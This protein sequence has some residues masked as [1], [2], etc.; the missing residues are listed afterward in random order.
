MPYTEFQMQL[1]KAYKALNP[2]WQPPP[3][4]A[5]THKKDVETG[6]PRLGWIQFVSYNFEGY[7]YPQY[8]FVCLLGDGAPEITAGY[9]GWEAIARARNVAFVQWNG[10][11][12]LTIK[13]PI[14]FDNWS[15]GTS[16][17]PDIRQ[18]EKM[19]GAEIN[20]KQPP[21]ILIDS[22]GV[23]PHD[24]HDASQNDWVIAEIEWGDSDRNEHGNRVRQ[25][26]TITLMEYNYDA[27]I[28]GIGLRPSAKSKRKAKAK[29]KRQP[30]VV[31]GS[32]ETLVSI[33]HRV[34]GNSHLWRRIRDV[35]K[36]NGKPIYTKPYKHIPMGTTLI[37]PKH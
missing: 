36:K 21:L 33:A 11:Q 34:L 20:M 15:L 13:I 17:E 35:N 32:N 6:S 27:V 25:A 7:S 26:A 8:S 31:R 5:T 12:P 2:D 3:P 10:R 4:P 30:Y 22:N 24:A 28:G 9:G 29:T 14:L 37:M 1:I 16:I 19:A 18:L 23:V